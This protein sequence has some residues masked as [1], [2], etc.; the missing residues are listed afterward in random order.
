MK[1]IGSDQYLKL[2][3]SPDWTF[4]P[5]QWEVQAWSYVLERTARLLYYS[6][7]LTPTHYQI[8]PGADGNG[9]LPEPMRYKGV[10]DSAAV[11]FRE[12]LKSALNLKPNARVAFMCDGPYGIVT[13]G[14]TVDKT[15]RR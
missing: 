1:L 10:P 7:Q 6:P 9:V 2:I 11:F 12:G 8:V 13:R 5:D 15:T 3:F 4:V 14:G